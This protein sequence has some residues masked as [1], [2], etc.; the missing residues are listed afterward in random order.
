MIS[1]GYHRL[2]QLIKNVPSGSPLKSTNQER[3]PLGLP[4]QERPLWVSSPSG[5]PGA[6][7]HLTVF[8]SDAFS[9][10][11]TSDDQHFIA[12]SLKLVGYTLD[13][14]AEAMFCKML[15]YEWKMW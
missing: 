14:H 4:N 2:S 1:A 7:E 3:P 10:L 5:S 6:G 13:L 12:T 9:W 15:I 8:R 11:D